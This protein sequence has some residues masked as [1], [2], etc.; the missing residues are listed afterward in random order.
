MADSK[1]LLTCVRVATLLIWK[2]IK[3]DVIRQ[4]LLLELS[5]LCF[6]V[7]DIFLALTIAQ[8]KNIAIAL[9]IILVRTN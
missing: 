8:A 1:L 4:H 7:L 9:A 5:R 3:N 6:I 2:N